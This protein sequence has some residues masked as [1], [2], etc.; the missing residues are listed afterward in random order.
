MDLPGSGYGQAAELFACGNACL[1][2]GGG[3]S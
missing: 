2:W 3:L 1:R